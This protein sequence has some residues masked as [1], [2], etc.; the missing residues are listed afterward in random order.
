MPHGEVYV[1][2]ND[3]WTLEKTAP[4]AGSRELVGYI[5]K[6][7]EAELRLA[8]K[9]RQK[10]SADP[11]TLR[12]GHVRLKNYGLD[13]AQLDKMIGNAVLAYIREV[14]KVEVTVSRR[15]LDKIREAAQDTR[16]KLTVDEGGV[17]AFPHVL[18]NAPVVVAASV[19]TPPL[20][21]APLLVAV[22]PVV[23]PPLAVTPASVSIPAPP[24]STT[25]SWQAFADALSPMEREA[26]TLLLSGGADLH[27]FATSHNLMLEVLAEGINEKA[28]DHIGDNLIDTDSGFSIFEDYVQDVMGAFPLLEVE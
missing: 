16:E 11:Q 8:M 3:R 9:H 7:T 19:D 22:P 20:T 18:G 6:K 27:A 4:F 13:F 15:S 26:V 17:G 12:Y 14:N 23:V 21:D 1:C 10:L 5:I 28:L 2:A 25:D 24:P